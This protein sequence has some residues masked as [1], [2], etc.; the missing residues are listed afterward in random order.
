MKNTAKTFSNTTKKMG[1]FGGIL[2]VLDGWLVKIQCPAKNGMEFQ[3]SAVFTV[4]KDIT[5]L[6]CRPFLIVIN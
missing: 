1:M 2:G 5:L 3:T 4:G 6:M